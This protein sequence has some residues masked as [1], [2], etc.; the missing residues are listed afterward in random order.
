VPML[1][2]P[3]PTFE[4]LFKLMAAGPASVGV[5][6]S[7][8]GQFIGGHGMNDVN[9]LKT[10][11]GMSALW[12]GEP[13]RRVRSGDG[14]SILPGRRVA[15]HLMVQPNVTDIL[16]QDQELA[17]QGILSRLLVSAP[18]SATGKRVPR[19][20]RPETESAI[21]SFGRRLLDILEAPLPLAAGKTNELEPRELPLSEEARKL[22]VEFGGH[23][24]KAMA[25]GGPLQQIKGLA[26]KL[27][28]HAARLAAV[29]TLV[30]NLQ[31]T[32]VGAAEMEAGIALAEYY[33]AEALRLFGAS[34]IG[35]DLQA[36]QR[37]LDWLCETWPE[38]NVSLPDIYQRGPN[39]IR[40]KAT[41]QKL[42][43]I[44]VDHGWLAP[45]QGGT[46]IGEQFRRQAWRTV[47]A[48]KET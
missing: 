48:A 41:A 43:A 39:S 20:E 10:V 19:P 14:A 21:N 17:G 31:A 40:D 12:D 38:D 33:A 26:N 23:V 3:E 7:E 27:P 34:Q 37:L 47:K 1:M 28:E 46:K 45:V 25:P 18:E 32:E 11:S 35:A 22:W 13:A 6:S 9:K 24:E 30:G 2:C 8:G 36:A 15:L 42:A 16:L 4:G 29:R 5:F 44:L